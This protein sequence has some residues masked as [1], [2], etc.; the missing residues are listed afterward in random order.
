MK[1]MLTS[2]VRAGRSWRA[3]W[4]SCTRER[5]ICRGWRASC[6]AGGSVPLSSPQGPS[7]VADLAFAEQMF[8][9][10]TEI[11]VFAAQR[12][13]ANEMAP[14]IDEL[15]RRAEDGLEGLKQKERTLRAKVRPPCSQAPNSL[16]VTHERPTFPPSSTSA[17]TGRETPIRRLSLPNTHHRRPK[18]ARHTRA[19]ACLAPAEEEPVREGSR[20]AG[21]AGCE[22]EKCEGEAGC[23]NGG[24]RGEAVMLGVMCVGSRLCCVSLACCKPVLR[25]QAVASRPA[26]PCSASFEVLLSTRDLQY[27]AAGILCSKNVGA[28]PR[29][30]S[31]L[32]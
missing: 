23:G 10:V 17:P 6:R 16:S 8:D 4:A 9:L 28:D 24:A 3:R 7:Q 22:G 29:R 1:R 2:F 14:Q 5:W 27:D 31:L 25:L 21:R 26:S 19:K 12:A 18:R 13:L 32:S 20:G 15:I 30:P 11:E